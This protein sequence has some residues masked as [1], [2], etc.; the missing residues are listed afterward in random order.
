[1]QVAITQLNLGAR[2]YH[3]IPKLARTITDLAWSDEIQ[4]TPLAKALQ[5]RPKIMMG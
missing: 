1:M 2:V 3:R 4:S 5:Y